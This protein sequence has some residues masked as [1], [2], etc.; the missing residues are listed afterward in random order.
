MYSDAR[1]S[2]KITSADPAASP[3]CAS[4]TC[5][6]T[7]DRREW[8]EAIR[9]ARAHPRPARVRA[10]QRR[11]DL[12]RAGGARP[13]RR[14]STGSRATPRPRC[15]PRARARMGSDDDVGA[16]P[17]TMRVHG[18]EACAWSMPRSMPLRHQRQHLRA[19]DDAGREGRRPDP[20]QH[21]ARPRRPPLLPLPRR[22]A[23]LSAGRRAQLEHA[24]AV[25]LTD[26]I[27]SGCGSP[28]G[29][30]AP[31]RAQS[32]PVVLLT[33]DAGLGRVAVAVTD[34]QPPALGTEHAPHT[35][36]ATGLVTVPPA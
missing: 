7:E 14:S 27:T 35:G 5:R 22:Y 11:R 8:V 21:A 30:S 20:R 31:E 24:Q 6:P 16:R 23:A 32:R 19:G 34:D 1:G 9:V 15:T 10:V 2:V 17:A 25:S 28:V 36:T 13:T 33:A 4:T 29:P 3:R 12:A 18:V 26:T